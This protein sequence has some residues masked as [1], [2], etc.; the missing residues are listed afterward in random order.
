[1]RDKQASEIRLLQSQVD[2]I[3]NTTESLRKEKE[4]SEATKS[5]L[6]SALQQQQQEIGTCSQVL[7]ESYTQKHVKLTADI[8]EKREQFERLK[9][10]FASECDARAKELK[11]LR[12]T[13]EATSNRLQDLESRAS[14]LQQN[15]AAAEAELYVHADWLTR[16]ANIRSNIQQ[17]ESDL[18]NTTSRL[19][20]STSEMTV[21]LQ[22]KS[23]TDTFYSQRVDVGRSNSIRS[24]RFPRRNRRSTSAWWRRTN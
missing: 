20:S 1:M 12:Q 15:S 18:A 23:D 8:N 14:E 13:I 5:Q 21:L 7:E 2:S 6:S 24:R 19:Q 16:R 10:Q 17:M 4:E 22:Q 11:E 3:T 9:E